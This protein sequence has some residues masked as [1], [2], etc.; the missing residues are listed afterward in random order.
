MTTTLKRCQYIPGFILVGPAKS[1]ASISAASVDIEKGDLL[2]DDGNG[3][4]TNAG[5]STLADHR[6][7]YVAIEPCSNSGGSV[8]DLDV[9]CVSIA[10]STNEF[11]VPVEEDGV[12]ERTDVGTLADVNSEDGITVASD[13][14]NTNNAFLIEGYDAGTEAVA[15]NTYGYAKGRF[16]PLGE[17]T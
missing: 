7:V 16:V 15:A 8:G 1:V 3:Y 10:D 9:L 4:I 14:T 11:W 2:M 17:T 5:I 12:I 6:N 13:V